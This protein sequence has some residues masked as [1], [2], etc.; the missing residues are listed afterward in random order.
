MTPP[1]VTT[2]THGIESGDRHWNSPRSYPSDRREPVA[3]FSGY[4]HALAGWREPAYRRGESLLHEPIPPSPMPLCCRYRCA[5]VVAREHVNDHGG[6]RLKLHAAVCA[7]SRWYE[8][9]P[10]G[11]S[12]A[13][14]NRDGP[15]ITFAAGPVRVGSQSTPGDRPLAA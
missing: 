11:M 9:L 14:V 4:Q 8:I 6:L 10:P 12:G 1:G 3:A 2:F 5:T 15:A 7:A 13:R